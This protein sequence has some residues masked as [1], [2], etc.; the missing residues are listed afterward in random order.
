MIVTT[1]EPDVFD[2]LGNDARV[3]LTMLLDSPR[4]TTLAHA[5]LQPVASG[6]ATLGWVRR[7][8]SC[9]DGRDEYAITDEGK[10]VIGSER[11]ARLRAA[12]LS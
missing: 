5:R 11:I 10:A 9:R 3:I 7:Y 1:T 2:A 6:L 12:R 4:P 8:R